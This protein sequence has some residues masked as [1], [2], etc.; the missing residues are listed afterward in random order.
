VPGGVLYHGQNIGRGA[1]EQVG[2]EEVARR[3]AS[4]WERRNFGQAGPDRRGARSSPAFSE[5][6]TP[7][8]PLPS[9]PGRPARRG[10]CGTPIRG[11]RGPAGGPGPGCCGGSQAG[12]SCRAWTWRPSGGGRCRG[13]S[14]G[15]CLGRPAAS[16][17]GAAV[18]VSPRA[19]VASRARSAQ[20][21]FGR[22][23]CRRCST[24]SWWRKIKISAVS[25]ASS[26]RDSR[27]HEATRV[28]RRKANR[29]HVIGDHHGWTAGRATLLVRAMDGI[30]GTHRTR[31]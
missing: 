28:I 16:A 29:R 25:H 14:A 11:S 21:T 22:R 26:R 3:I 13:A 8:R 30:L 15:S 19:G 7:S 6:P 10:S 12:R 18:S 24:A 23:G 1:V 20:F 31:R 17:P 5:F 4:A 2:R 9:L 27:S